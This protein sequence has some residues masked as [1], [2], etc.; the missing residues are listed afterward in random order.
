[1][2]LVLSLKG[3]VGEMK[4]AFVSVVNPEKLRR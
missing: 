4:M 1:M 3:G 2:H